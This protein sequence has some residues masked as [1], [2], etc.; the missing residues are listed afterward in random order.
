MVRRRF[1]VISKDGP[2]AATAA[3]SY[4]LLRTIMGRAVVEGLIR[5][6]PGQLGARWDGECR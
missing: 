5:S 6:K 2:G 3:K 4:R 1:S